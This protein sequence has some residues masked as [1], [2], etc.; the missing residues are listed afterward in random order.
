MAQRSD[1]IRLFTPGPVEVHPEI[2]QAQ[3]RWMIG[4]RQEAYREVHRAVRSGLQWMFNTK[5]DVIISTSSATGAWEGCARN[6]VKK[7]CLQLTNGNFSERWEETTRL[8]GKPLGTYQ[9]DWGKAH[10]PEELEKHLASGKYDAVAIVHSETSTG[11]LN[12]L[13]ELCAVCRKFPDVLVFVDAVSSAATLPIDVEALG[14]DVLLVGVQKGFGLPPG[15]AFYTLSPRALERSAGIPDRGY[16]FNW[17]ILAKHSKADETPATPP[18]SLMFAL[19]T[20]LERIKKETLEGRWARHAAL[21]NRCR[22]WAI[23]RGQT[24]FPEKGRESVGL[25]CIANQRGWDVKALHDWLLKER[26]MAMD[27][28]YGKLKG[29]TFRIAHMADC[30]VADLDELLGAI[31]EFTSRT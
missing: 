1:H 12:P 8:C 28:G 4:H 31:D 11:V 9:V 16:Y 7:G 17:E 20:Q 27:Q 29:K 6:G 25:T 5:N 19:Q 21:A 2:L 24:L 22:S 3:S 14:I 26:G 13:A 18:V 23:E 10:R 15:L 30:Q